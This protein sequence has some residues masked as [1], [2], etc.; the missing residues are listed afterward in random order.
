MPRQAFF[1]AFLPFF[2]S[3]FFGLHWWVLPFFCFLCIWSFSVFMRKIIATHPLLQN[4]CILLDQV[5]RLPSTYLIHRFLSNCYTWV[6]SL[7]FQSAVVRGTELQV[8][9]LTLVPA[10]CGA[11][12]CGWVLR[13]CKLGLTLL[14]SAWELPWYRSLSVKRIVLNTKDH[15]VHFLPNFTATAVFDDQLIS[16]L[17]PL[18]L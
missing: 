5:H 18:V 9:N 1:S 2:L 4:V 17:E 15:S 3:L 12:E 16:D 13:E 10:L 11:W 14:E 7:L 6:R 8:I